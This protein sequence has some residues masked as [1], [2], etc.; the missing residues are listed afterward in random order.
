MQIIQSLPKFQPQKSIV[1]HTRLPSSPVKEISNSGLGGDDVMPGLKEALFV[2]FSR[3]PP[4]LTEPSTGS[5]ERPVIPAWDT[6]TC[7]I[8]LGDI[9][10]K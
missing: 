8:L 6:A 5:S 4:I 9:W 10:Q 7:R 1:N 2:V 3:L